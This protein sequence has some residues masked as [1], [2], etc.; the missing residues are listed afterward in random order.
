MNT[1]TEQEMLRVI[2]EL[3][4]RL[5]NWVEIADEED[6]REEDDAALAAADKVLKK[7]SAL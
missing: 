3:R 1:T 7:W 5:S 4:L 6:L 2:K